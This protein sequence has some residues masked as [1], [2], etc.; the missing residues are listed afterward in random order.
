MAIYTPRG[1]KIRLGVNYAFALMARL[2]PKVDAFKVLKT[3]E[4]L[5]LIPNML[6]FITGLI[7]FSLKIDGIQMSIY[8][9]IA[10]VIGTI[11]TLSGMFI[12]PGLPKLATLF[13]Y[14][15]GFGILSILIALYGF[16]FVGWRGVAAYFIGRILGE[17]I[18]YIIGFFSTKRAH[19]KTGISLTSVERNFF[20]A[21]R[22]YASKINKTIGIDVSDEELEEDTWFECFED[23]ATKYPEVTRRFTN[24]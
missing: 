10:T 7:L 13:S 15:H 14:I 5:E 20:N 8:V 23:F 1:L 3:T 6:A 21:Y 16:A 11:I 22:L 24:D 9:L 2:Y 18:N 17:I 12:F 4:G 19:L